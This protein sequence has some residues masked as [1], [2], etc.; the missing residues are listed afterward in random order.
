MIIKNTINNATF[1][2]KVRKVI[3]AEPGFKAVIDKDWNCGADIRI[4][5]AT[6]NAPF[7]VMTTIAEESRVKLRMLPADLDEVDILN[8]KHRLDSVDK[9]AERIQRLVEQYKPNLE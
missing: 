2:R 8:L 9:I 1:A 5:I 7:I 3:D 6:S 4:E